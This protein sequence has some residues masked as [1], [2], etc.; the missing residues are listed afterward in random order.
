MKLVPVLI[1][2]KMTYKCIIKNILTKLIKSTQSNI[3]A[4]NNIKAINENKHK[5]E[6]P[7]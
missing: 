1:I 5:Q 2:H 3:T 4:Y 7:L 6:A